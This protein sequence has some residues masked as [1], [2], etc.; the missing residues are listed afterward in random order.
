MQVMHEGGVF[1]TRT[2]DRESQDWKE[3][4]AL[5]ASLAPALGMV[6]GVTHAEYIKR[7]RRWA[8]LLS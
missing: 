8:L 1:T 6:R 2:V 7:A 3:L 4:T 5:N